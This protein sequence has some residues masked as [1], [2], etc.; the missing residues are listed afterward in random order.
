MHLPLR[1][2]CAAVLAAGALTAAA[3]PLAAAPAL[4]PQI[5]VNV[6]A[7]DRNADPLVAV[8]PDGG[9]VVVWD[10]SARRGPGRFTSAIHARVFHADGSPQTGEFLL[11]NGA[12]VE[13][14]AADGNERF[15]LA[16]NGVVRLWSRA[17]AP[18]TPAVPVDPAPPADVLGFNHVRASSP[19]LPT[20]EACITL[21][22]RLSY[23]A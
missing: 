3:P 11:V 5:Q 9:F 22:Y 8:F 20:P 23:E 15:V 17:G 12:G 19:S 13:S 21:G 18:L 10:A 6:S 7:L 16:Y 1:S 14:V 2:L 4:G